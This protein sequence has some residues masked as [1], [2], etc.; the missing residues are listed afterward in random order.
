LGCQFEFTAPDSPQKNGKVESKFA[1]VYD[2]IRAMLNE[3]E[4]NWSLRHAM[5]AYASLHATK[6]IRPDTHLLK[7][8]SV[9]AAPKVGLMKV[10]D[11]RR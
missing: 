5:W 4:F 9:M 6:L 1:T 8:L 3:A 2:R 11:E 10:G 7:Y